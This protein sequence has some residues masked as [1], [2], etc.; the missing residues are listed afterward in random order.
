MAKLIV[1]VLLAI[2]ATYMEAVISL[3]KKKNRKVIPISN[4]LP[5]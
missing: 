5:S 4:Q 2:F 1:F 3:G